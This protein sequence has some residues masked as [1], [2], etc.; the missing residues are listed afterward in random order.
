[1]QPDASAAASTAAAAGGSSGPSIPGDLS[2]QLQDAAAAAAAAAASSGSSSSL[3]LDSLATAPRDSCA[4]AAAALTDAATFAAAQPV[5]P[6]WQL[7]S[8]AVLGCSVWEM[9]HSASGLPWWA[10]I[11][12]TTLGLRTLLLPLTLKAKSAGLNFVLAQHATQT[13]TNLV[14]QWRQQQEAAQQPRAQPAAAPSS[15]SSSA[16]SSSGRGASSRAA[17]SS[18]SS[19]SSSG[20]SSSR[21]VG[22]GG[23][24]A[25]QL[26]RP[27][28]WRLTR[29]YYRYYRKQHGTTSLWWWTA[30][31][32][33]Q[34]RGVC[35]RAHACG[36]I[37]ACRG[38]QVARVLCFRTVCRARPRP[39]HL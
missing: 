16:S 19:S 6:I 11:P 31:V 30:N 22:L 8:P 10:S 33:V 12:L 1:L 18:S 29:M 38:Q 2:N 35:A 4:A 13:A 36:G 34:V 39:G 7:L 15:S 37:G 32:A 5:E 24:Q 26:K 3:L 25:L 23:G 20:G 17:S 27:S 21:L 28:R 14:E 9:V